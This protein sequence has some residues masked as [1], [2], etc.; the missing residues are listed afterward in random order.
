MGEAA[1]GE[2]AALEGA[3]WL[4]DAE[5]AELQ[6]GEAAAARQRDAFSSRQRTVP[7]RE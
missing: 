7:A 6:V 4:D 1:G 5:G 2:V 3:T